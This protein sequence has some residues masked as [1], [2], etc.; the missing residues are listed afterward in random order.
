MSKQPSFRDATTGMTASRA[1]SRSLDF[2]LFLGGGHGGKI[3]WTRIDSDGKVHLFVRD[4]L[5]EKF[6]SCWM[7]G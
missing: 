3:H 5:I 7:R 4:L 2:I 6:H 1:R